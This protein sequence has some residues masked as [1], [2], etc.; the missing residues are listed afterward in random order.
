MKNQKA[1]YQELVSLVA[2][3]IISEK[4]E[5]TSII[6]KKETILLILSSKIK[7]I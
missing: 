4:F 5:L 6:E 3:G 1:L 2:P 7:D